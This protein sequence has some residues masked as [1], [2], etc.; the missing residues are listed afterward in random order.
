MRSSRKSAA[1]R[2]R[3]GGNE[4]QLWQTSKASVAWEGMHMADM[5]MVGSILVGAVNAILAVVLLVVYGRVYANTKAPF[6]FAL[7]LFSAAFLAHNALVVYSF[8][9]MMEVVPAA[10]NPYLLGIGML[11]VGGLGAILWTATR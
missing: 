1:E 7:M 5:L 3:S 6:T 9:A 2:S 11:E 4:A 8:T 10:M